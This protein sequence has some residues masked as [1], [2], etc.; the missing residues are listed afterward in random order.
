MKQPWTSE[1]ALATAVSGWLEQ[2]GWECFHEVCAGGGEPRADI[3]ATQGPLV[4]V[5]ECKLRL[6]VDVL[7][8]ADAWRRRGSAHFV[9]MAV[10]GGKRSEGASFL[11]HVARDRGIG[12]IRV[13]HPDYVA[14]GDV[15]HRSF[16]GEAIPMDFSRWHV[17]RPALLRRANVAGLRAMLTPERKASRPGSQGPYF[18]PFRDT[19]KR[20]IEHVLEAGGRAV[21]RDTIKAISHHYSDDKSARGALVAMAKKGI[22]PGL[23]IEQDGRTLLFVTASDSPPGGFGP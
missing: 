4:W 9:S 23:R 11:E 7:A 19:C 17:S 14:D 3:V 8:Q 5:V 12:V 15:W 6:G 21:V 13:P 2:Q 1:E 16:S 20:V 22:V 10:P 18:T